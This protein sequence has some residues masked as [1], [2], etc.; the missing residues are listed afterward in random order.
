MLFSLKFIKDNEGDR[1]WPPYIVSKPKYVIYVCSFAGHV[2]AD[3]ST[4][5]SNKPEYETRPL[6]V[7]CRF[8]KWMLLLT[9]QVKVSDY[10]FR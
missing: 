9:T 1:V 10:F 6:W 3:L 2:N 8:T 4:I 5:F 7:Q